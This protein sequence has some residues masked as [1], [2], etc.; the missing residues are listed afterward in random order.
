LPSDIPAN[1]W[2][3]YRHQ[4]WTT[5]ADWLGKDERHSKNREWR[6]FLE[7]RDDARTL[8]LRN[9]AEWSAFCKSGNLPADIPADP[10]KVYRDLGWISRGDWLGTKTVAVA[11]REFRNFEDAREFVRSHHFQMKTEYEAW[12]RR[13]ER[14]SDIPAQPSR[15]YATTGWLG[16][17]DWLGIHNRWSKTSILA[18]VSSIV[19]L[20][21]RFQP[22]EI[23]AILRQNGCLIA[24][25]SLADTSP[26]KHLVE[27]VL[28]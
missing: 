28:H 23:Y 18:F 14:P 13:S 12:A 11:K 19:P 1:P 20:L 10:A 26:L 5:I 15:T 3:V 16:W 24:T 9:G 25:D 6:P 4:G 7:A 8:G 21:N 27:A 17:G 2:S 22:S